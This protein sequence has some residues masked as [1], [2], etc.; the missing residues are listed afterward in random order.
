MLSHFTFSLFDYAD[1]IKNDILFVHDDKTFSYY[2][3]EKVMKF[4]K[5]G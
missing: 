2:E 1:D 4:I 5:G 3:S